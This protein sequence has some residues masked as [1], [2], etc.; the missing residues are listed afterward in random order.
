MTKSLRNI[1][2]GVLL[3][4]GMAGVSF[5]TAGVAANVYE[6]HQHRQCQQSEAACS[7]LTAQEIRARNNQAYGAGA[8]GLVFLMV[9]GMGFRALGREEKDNRASRKPKSQNHVIQGKHGLS[10][11]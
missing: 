10:K 4:G 1:F 8:L 11:K 7:S 9:G 5:G 6:T 2:S 3:A